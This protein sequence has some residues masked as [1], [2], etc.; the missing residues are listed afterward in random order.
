VH[1]KEWKITSVGMDVKKSP[2]SK[3]AIGHLA[4][5]LGNYLKAQ[6]YL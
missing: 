2:P 3:F 4:N 1:S 6:N 5:S